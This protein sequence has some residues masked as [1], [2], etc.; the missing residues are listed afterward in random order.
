MRSI[1]GTHIHQNHQYPQNWVSHIMIFGHIG[2]QQKFR[3][4]IIIS[5][6]SVFLAVYLVFFVTNT[7]IELR[8]SMLDKT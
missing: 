3:L 5:S 6:G 2:I 7:Q 4:F 8:R 1:F